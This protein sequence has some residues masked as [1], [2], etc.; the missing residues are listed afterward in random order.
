M[1]AVCKLALGSV[2]AR[3]SIDDECYEAPLLDWNLQAKPRLSVSQ[4]NV[5][6]CSKRG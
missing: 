6:A 1:Y 3:L 5:V 4:C 2:H